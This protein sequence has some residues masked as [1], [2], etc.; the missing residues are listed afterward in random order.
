MKTIVIAAVAAASA[1]TGC[2]G[3]PPMAA[4]PSGPCRVDDAL[5]REFAAHRANRHNAAC[6]HGHIGH[7]IAAR[8]RVQHASVRDQ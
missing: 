1:L 6:G 2:V 4:T 3:T 7:L 8:A 5:R